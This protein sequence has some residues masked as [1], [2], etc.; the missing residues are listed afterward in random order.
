MNKYQKPYNKTCL[1]DD[2]LPKVTNAKGSEGAQAPPV[3]NTPAGCPPLLHS[4]PETFTWCFVLFIFYSFQL[5]LY[6]TLFE[7][8]EDVS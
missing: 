2:G 4:L 3:P 7:T 8:P 6:L 1:F 5:P